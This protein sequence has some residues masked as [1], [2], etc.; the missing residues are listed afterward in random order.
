MS[1]AVHDYLAAI[2]R[3]GGAATSEAKARASRANGKLG[4]RPRKRKRSRPNKEV[5]IE[6]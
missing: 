4:G 3:R 6:R 1:D 5:S 2:G